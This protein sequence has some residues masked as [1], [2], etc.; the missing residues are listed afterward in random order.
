MRAWDPERAPKGKAKS[1]GKTK[2]AAKGPKGP[3]GKPGGKGRGE[4][5]APAAPHRSPKEKAEQKARQAHERYLRRTKCMGCEP[6]G[7]EAAPLSDVRL[8]PCNHI[9][10][11]AACATK[12]RHCP[13]CRTLIEDRVLLKLHRR[14]GVHERRG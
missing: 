14:R 5:A 11:C 8:R 2:G 10:M 6:S 7:L 13:L 4:Q 1:K 9:V 12:R 3:N